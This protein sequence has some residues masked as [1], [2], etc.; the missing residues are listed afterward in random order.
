MK[1]W[2]VRKYDKENLKLAGG[3]KNIVGKS[4]EYL[5]SCIR[6]RM[7]VLVCKERLRDFDEY[8]DR[9]EF[10]DSGKERGL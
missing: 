1:S 9:I 8:L 5:E 3:R 4:K 6:S 10:G 7:D 2:I